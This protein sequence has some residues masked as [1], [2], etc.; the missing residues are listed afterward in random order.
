MKTKSFLCLLYLSIST[1]SVFSQTRL[2]WSNKTKHTLSSCNLEGTD[3]REILRTNSPVDLG[4][5][6]KSNEIYFTDFS[7]KA[8]YA[9]NVETNKRRLVIDSLLAPKGVVVDD[10]NGKLYWCDQQEGTIFK[11]SLTGESKEP[12]LDGLT[13]PNDLAID[14][15]MG[16]LYWSDVSENVIYRA[17]IDGSDQTVL[18]ENALNAV[19]LELSSNQQTLFWLQD[20]QVNTSSGVR[21]INVDGTDFQTINTELSRTFTLDTSEAKIYWVDFS[22]DLHQVSFDGTNDETLFAVDARQLAFR[23]NTG[24]FYW[25]RRGQVILRR[26]N[27]DGSN[28]QNMAYND[29]YKPTGLVVDT[30]TDHI[31]YINSSD[32]FN[33]IPGGAIMRTTLNGN[34]TEVIISDH[35]ILFEPLYID[36]DNIA[37]KMYWTDG[38]R[39]G[40]SVWRANLDGTE[41][42]RLTRNTFG[43]RGISIDT[44]REVVYWVDDSQKELK[45]INADGNGGE[46]GVFVGSDSRLIDAFYHNNRVFWSDHQQ[47]TMYFRTGALPTRFFSS[48]SSRDGLVSPGPVILSSKEST[49]PLTF[50]W[51]DIQNNDIYESI[52]TNTF[53]TR[54][55]IDLDTEGNSSSIYGNLI[56]LSLYDESAIEAD[57]DED[58]FYAS[59]DCD[60]ENAKINAVALEVPNN[61]IDEDCDGTALVIDVDMDGF[62]SDE[63]CN[64]ENAAINPAATEIPDNGVDEDCNG[65][66]L[67][68]SSIYEVESAKISIYPNP[69]RDKLVI[70]FD[71]ISQLQG[72]ILDMNGRTIRVFTIRGGMNTIDVNDLVSGFYYL[73]VS[74]TTT[75]EYIID[76]IVKQ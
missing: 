34:R 53:E 75:T 52:G 40:G 57:K 8:I 46:S 65:E 20:G 21:S 54:L 42:E 62:N 1:L 59:E 17:A 58:G 50:Y 33:N 71:G 73:R 43:P 3:V 5:S 28:V 44:D 19:Q 66:D 51:I 76:K 67:I 30:I 24:E 12:V 4:F 45:L 61:D 13:A 36:V 47:E 63:D 26:S 22:G 18:A 60:D 39:D 35:S 9:I 29:V 64:D 38:K 49:N 55:I 16:I 37:S 23:A 68:T 72:E 10:E 48:L 31:Y 74:S 69:V 11:S 56:G 70:G 15:S 32:G 2:V 25:T 14:F 7:K 6:E 41:I 27:A